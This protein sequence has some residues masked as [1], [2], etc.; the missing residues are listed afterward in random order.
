MN[1]SHTPTQPAESSLGMEQK[2]VVLC[3]ELLLKL[4]KSTHAVPFL[5]PVDPLRLNIP[6]YHEKIKHPMD[7]ST[8]SK[9]LE[10]GH[11]QTMDAFKND[12]SLMFSNCYTYNAPGSAV[13]KMG[14][15]LE[16]YYKQLLNKGTQE[17]K[18]RSEEPEIE[19]KRSKTR[20]MSD[21][22][23]TK[24]LDALNE[25]VRVKYRRFNWPFLEAVDANMVPNYYTLIKHPMD[26][27]LMRKKLT[28]HQYNS[29]E[30]FLSDF[31]LMISNCYTFNI[32]DSEVYNC[33]TKLNA[34]FKQAFDQKKKKT[35][36]DAANRIAILKE[37]I[38]QYESELRKLEKKHPSVAGY[39][40][41]EKKKL[42]KRIETLP[43]DKLAEIVLYAQKNIPTAIMTETNE[44]E[45]D[46]DLLDHATLSKLDSMVKDTSYPDDLPVDSDS[47]SE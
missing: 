13:Y 10:S 31:D 8:I 22:D 35:P 6:D 21:E 33:A 16:K 44:L 38:A 42:K 32:K 36:D 26:L 20:T 2:E 39:T 5:Y 17:T 14:Q 1:H 34:Q 7:L 25:I 24:C 43:A 37:M 19:K 41:D 9:N 18:K 11:Y 30:E 23:Y 40:Y 15:Q 29:V 28:T 4:K 3:K 47:S 45:I 12:I 27:S 46:F